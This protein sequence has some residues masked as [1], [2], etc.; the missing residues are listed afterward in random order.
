MEGSKKYYNSFYKKLSRLDERG[1]TFDKIKFILPKLK[2]EAKI[3]DIGCGHGSV[4]HEL[5]KQGYQVYGMEINEDAIKSLK[6]KKINVIKCDITKP[7][8]LEKQFDIVLL[9]DVLEHVFDPLSLI[10]EVLK[11]LKVGGYIIISVPLYFDLIDRIRILFTGSIISYDNLCYGKANY[12]KFRSYNY[13]HIRFFRPKDIFEICK[14]FKLH[15]EMIKYNPIFGIGRL[16]AFFV[17]LFVNK[18]TTNL[19]PN[20]LAHSMILR[21]K[22]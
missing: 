7:F 14:S 19:W 3:I 17:K 1:N 22:K 10:N 13:D 18:I 5:V 21:V 12:I 9:L 16:S 11:I 15:I 6:K 2:S 4:S 8:N 20:L